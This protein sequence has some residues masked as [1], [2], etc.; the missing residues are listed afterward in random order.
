MRPVEQMSDG[1]ELCLGGQHTP[2][3]EGGRRGRK[4]ES[5][6]GRGRAGGRKGGSEGRK[7]GEMVRRGRVCD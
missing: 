7:E 4:G 5:K 1:A 6:A 2:L 3:G